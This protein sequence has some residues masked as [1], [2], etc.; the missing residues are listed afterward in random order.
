MN[1]GII[2]PFPFRPHNQ[3][4]VFLSNCIKKNKNIK[5]FFA[6]CDGSPTLC[7]N[8]LINKKKL[9]IITCK[10]C[11]LFGLKSFL[12]DPFEKISVKNLIE[13][14]SYK[15]N[16]NLALS[17]LYTAYRTES[18]SDVIVAKKSKDFLI[19]KQ[20]SDKF[21][22]ATKAWIKNNKL[23]AVI[24]FN[25]RIDLLKAVR[26]ACLETSINF[27]SVERPW[28][29]KGLLLVPNEAPSGVLELERI[30]NDFKNKPLTK[31]QIIDVFQPILKRYKKI[32][33]NEAR[34][35]NIG[36][37]D[38][39][40]KDI[41]NKSRKK[42]LFLPSSRA[43]ILADIDFDK[44]DWSHPIEGLKYLINENILD[45]NDLI[46]RF[47]PIWSEILFN[48][49][50]ESI[51]D[52]FKSFCEEYNIKYIDSHEK[53]DTNFL[54]R[55]SDL[56]IINGSSSF[57]EASIIGK[58]IL[59][60]A[61][62]FYDCSNIALNFHSS[63]DISKICIFFKNNFKIDKKLQIKKSIRFMYIFKNRF[64]QFI[65]NVY[66]NSPFEVYYNYENITSDI[67]SL[68]SE[69]KLI[70]Y[71]KT[72]SNSEDEEDIFIEKFLKS[73]MNLDSIDLIEDKFFGEKIIRKPFYNLIDIIYKK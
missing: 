36:H 48:K 38:F 40:W 50:G 65:D 57:L 21:K 15:L 10:A 60:L 31:N 14:P 69:G 33:I 67:I 41:N 71:D 47:H 8:K 61:K 37:K 44:D 70:P 11:Q 49:N 24:G 29:E 6:E 9:N 72:F 17:S 23:T 7:Y 73:E 22:R 12:N 52:F 58:P 27:I 16:D 5:L 35:F 13:L 34:Q 66:Y 42:I 45:T 51:I 53:I 63:K 30:Y 1:I 46:V 39:E 4:L 20:E 55:Q 56:L 59:S 68:C 32:N 64:T 26:I 54:I 25:G 62:S 18:E 2:N 43:E 3:D 28:F 19:L